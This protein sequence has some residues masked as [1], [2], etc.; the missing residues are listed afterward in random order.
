M[1]KTPLGLRIRMTGEHPEAADTVGINVRAVTVLLRNPQRLSCRTGRSLSVPCSAQLVQQGHVC[2]ARL[3]GPGRM[4]LR[5]L[6]SHWG[7]GRQ[8]PILIYRCHTDANAN[9]SDT[10]G[11]GDNPDDPLHPDHSDSCRGSRQIEATGGSGRTLRIGAWEEVTGSMR[12]C[13]TL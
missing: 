6:E 9:G 3:H 8:L 5:R 4:H 10:A 13:G 2:R 12:V 7:P 11:C 1:F